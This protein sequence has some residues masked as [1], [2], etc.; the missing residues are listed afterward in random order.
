MVKGTCAAN[1]SLC[2]TLRRAAWPEGSASMSAALLLMVLLLVLVPALF[3]LA[4]RHRSH[5]L[6]EELSPISRQ[7]IDLFQGGQLPEAAVEAAKA[8]FRELLERGEVGAVESSLRAGMQYVVQVRALAELGTDDA[9]RILERQLQRRLTDDHIEQA[10]YWIDLANG[11][12]SLNRA[13][14]LPHLLRCAEAASDL[15][16]GHFFAAET[17]CFLGFTG[18][19]RQPN[20]AL[21]RSALRVLHRALEGLRF[22]VP[23]TVVAE[24]RMGELVEALWDYREEN[25]NPLVARVFQESLRVVRRAEHASAGLSAEPS[26]AEAFEWQVSRLVALEPVLQDYLSEAGPA[27]NERLRKLDPGLP[28]SAGPIRDALL[29]LIDLRAEAGEAVL[30]L[31]AATRFPHLDLVVEALTWSQSPRVG[32]ALR[33]WALARVPMVR[34]A[35]RRRRAL[36]SRRPSL[37]AEVPYRALLRAL[38]GHP[39]AQT[40]AFLMLATRDWDP[41]YRAAAVGSLG[42]WEP[43]SRAEVLLTLQDARRDPSPEVRQAAYGALARLGER[44][45]LLRFRQ[46]LTSEDPQRAFEAIQAIASE[47]LTLLW[48][49]LDKMADN[50]ESE[51]AHHAR[52]A[53]ERLGEDLEYRRK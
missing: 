11:L 17:V 41:T 26:E 14:S 13:Q 30:P 53:L 32:P 24:A 18:Y 46:T 29:A 23:P 27:L 25:V 9:G 38:R 33:E 6:R 12:R 39:S 1:E 15:P 47:G 34:R 45:A 44:T 43:L 49:D 50:E 19:V 21:G 48:P 36:P 3:L 4:R 8:R 7:H 51:L 42:W 22:G 20:T 10:W 16:L 28:E 31:L 40:E 35:H 2:P 37:P 5:G 52:E